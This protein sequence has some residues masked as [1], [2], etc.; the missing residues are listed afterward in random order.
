MIGKDEIKKIEKAVEFYKDIHAKYHKCMSFAYESVL[1]SNDKKALK[2][3]HVETFE[4][5]SIKPYIDPQVKQLSDCAPNIK[6]NGN[7]NVKITEMLNAF[8][9]KVKKQSKFDSQTYKTFKN[10][11]IG[12]ISVLKVK[13]AY[14][15]DDSM[16]QDI[17]IESVVNPTCVYFDP[18][19]REDSKSDADWV[20]E[21]VKYS[22][23]AFIDEF[24]QGSYDAAIKSYKG[25]D[26]S[27][28]KWVEAEKGKKVKH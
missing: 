23:D 5:Q 22:K 17:F 18:A 3:N 8:F 28:I 20:F 27:K 4:V 15:S 24:G 12:G 7:N 11:V 13:T 6:F 10:S 16:D 21:L 19:A 1:S 26:S 9:D 2:D 14:C 25:L